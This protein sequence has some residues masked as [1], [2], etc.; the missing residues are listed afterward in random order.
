LCRILKAC[1]KKTKLLIWESN[2]NICIIKKKK[3][4]SLIK[5]KINNV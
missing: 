3:N 4:N 2:E 5:L 1:T